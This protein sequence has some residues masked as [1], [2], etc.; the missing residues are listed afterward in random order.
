MNRKYMFTQLIVIP[1]LLFGCVNRNVHRDV[2]TSKNDNSD[3]GITESTNIRVATISN[4]ELPNRP[5]IDRDIEGTRNQQFT[6][7]HIP[8][9]RTTQ[10]GRFAMQA[11]TK[12]RFDFYLFSPE[13]IDNPFLASRNGTTILADKNPYRFSA[14]EF[15]GDSIPNPYHSGI[16]E[17]EQ[18][19]TRCGLNRNDCY[20]LTIIIPSYDEDKHQL[21]LI[22]TP[23]RVEIDSPKSRAA[24]IKSITPGQPVKGVVWSGIDGFLETNITTDGHLI[25]GRVGF[26]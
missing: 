10:D 5:S 19:P 17:P 12:N 7:P 8:P 14:E 26:F 24:S 13:K 21:Q 6:R 11:R 15:P 25:V 22:G 9:F 23:I 1:I 20:N 2:R 4:N 16:C 3:Q 18:N